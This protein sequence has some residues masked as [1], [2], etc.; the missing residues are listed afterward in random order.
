MP[1]VTNHDAFRGDNLL[2]KLYLN[3]GR[4][5]AGNAR[6]LISESAVAELCLS[7]TVILFQ[8]AFAKPNFILHTFT[9]RLREWCSNR[10]LCIYSKRFWKNC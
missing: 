5:M 2:G 1:G 6:E 10:N 4:F 3:Y 8:A 7:R 9:K